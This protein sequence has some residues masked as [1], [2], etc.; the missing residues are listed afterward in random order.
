M[1]E[2]LEAALNRLFPRHGQTGTSTQVA[3]PPGP[4]APAAPAPES[5]DELSSR[6]VDHYRRALQAQ[7]DGN[8][9]LYGEEIRRL[10]DVLEQ[11]RR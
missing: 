11:M 5:T 3:P 8:W 6:A 1:D 4:G 10:G 9:A 2:T 7:R